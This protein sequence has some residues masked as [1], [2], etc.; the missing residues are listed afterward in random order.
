[1]GGANGAGVGVS[2]DWGV[3]K[4][5]FKISMLIRKRTNHG[6]WRGEGPMGLRW[7]NLIKF[8]EQF[9]CVLFS[10]VFCSEYLYGHVDALGVGPAE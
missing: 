9:A 6:G 5:F 7:S 4:H 10:V 3:L 2:V 1:M 8:F